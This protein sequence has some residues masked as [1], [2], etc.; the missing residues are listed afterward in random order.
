MIIVMTFTN[1]FHVN[2][3]TFSANQNQMRGQRGRAD[4]HSTAGPGSGEANPRAIY[5]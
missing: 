1:M 5:C 2:M 3:E 4:R